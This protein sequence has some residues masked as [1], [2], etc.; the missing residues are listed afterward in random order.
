MREVALRGWERRPGRLVSEIERLWELYGGRICRAA[1]LLVGDRGEAEALAQDVFVSAWR[2]LDSFQG[3]SSEYTW[4][5]SI[6]INAFRNRLRDRRRGAQQLTEGQEATSAEPP[7]EAQVDELRAGIL[8]ALNEL[9][10]KHREVLVMHF[11]EG[12]KYSEMAEA[13]GCRLGTVKSRLWHAKRKLRERLGRKGFE[14]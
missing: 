3:R 13:L 9:E 10:G 2:S 6:L 14:Y 11:L 5:Y 7:E 12:M 1:Y 8:S 4:L